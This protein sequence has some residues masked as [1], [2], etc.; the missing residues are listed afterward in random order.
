M[1]ESTGAADAELIARHRRGD[2]K[3]FEELVGRYVRLAG[4]IAYHILRDYG[5][6]A[7]VV[8][9][10]FLKV[11]SAL[12]DLREPEKFKGWLYGV[13][14]SC[15]LDAVRRRK[16]RA[17]TQLSA[18]DG[19]ENL[20]PDARAEDGPERALERR[21]LEGVVLAGVDKLPESYR[22]V[23]VLKY[24]DERS[25]KEI[26]EVLGI[27]VEAIESRLH[28]ARKILRKVFAAYAPPSSQRESQQ[29]P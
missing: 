4:G 12:P 13:V 15:A 25:Y 1:P 6:A 9:E 3:A 2:P 8:Q 22:E 29:E 11:H 21:E 27:S 23:V 7:D 14:R 16:Y 19:R 28:R 18:L 24:M 17:A 10:A 20:V 5:S 26:S